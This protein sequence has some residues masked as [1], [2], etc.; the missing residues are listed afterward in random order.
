MS[1]NTPY[2]ENDG[3]WNEIPLPEPDASW[4]KMNKMLEEDDRR[5]FF[6]F[7]LTRMTGFFLF[8]VILAGTGW[9][10]LRQQHNHNPSP[11]AKTYPVKKESTTT[12]APDNNRDNKS[13]GTNVSPRAK[14]NLSFSAGDSITNESIAKKDSNAQEKFAQVHANGT[15]TQ[16]VNAKPDKVSH[17]KEKRIPVRRLVIKRANYHTQNFGVAGLSKINKEQKDGVKTTNML[18]R[19]IVIKD[20]LVQQDDNA[21][22]ND[23]NDRAIYS[24]TGTTLV[25][26]SIIA[27]GKD[28]GSKAMEVQKSVAGAKKISSKT[29]GAVYFSAGLGVQQ[30]LRS[31]RQVA[32]SENY[33]G[34]NDV[35][36]EHIPSVFVS[37]HKQNKWFIQGE[38]RFGAPQFVENYTY[39]R[40]V[41]YSKQDS[42]LVT[43]SLQLRKL[44]YHQLPLSF[45]YNV[46]P[47]FYIGAGGVYSMFY[48][49]VTER[50]IKSTSLQT[51]NEIFSNNI[52]RT[53]A[54]NDSFF[55]RSQVQVMVQA[56]Y[57]WKRWTIGL[58]YKKDLQP[59][60]RYMQPDGTVK[61][62]M[63]DALDAAI[64]YQLWKSKKR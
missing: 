5:R 62:E 33:Y 15:E 47:H 51:G 31:S 43:T 20:W 40:Q 58:C 17:A 37:I 38:F 32:Y 3:L 16:I 52:V 4:Q 18:D 2:Q 28:T 53:P 13:V 36:S 60:I 23:K 30:Q 22:A 44:Y 35:L 9:L 26:P 61:E 42:T 41:L 49:A 39:A 24:D 25:S 45:N 21:S 59:Y 50:S 27:T 7:F 48:R 29:P 8:I 56:N 57:Q 34:K 54:Y 1:E 14:S 63:N 10:A 19:N 11:V 46:A 12:I 6:P 55:F 64:R